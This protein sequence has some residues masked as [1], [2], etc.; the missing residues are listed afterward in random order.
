MDSYFPQGNE[1]TNISKYK[2]KYKILVTQ[3]KPATS[4]NEARAVLHSLR[5]SSNGKRHMRPPHSDTL[6]RR[7][8]LILLSPVSI[9][10]RTGVADT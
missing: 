3:V 1:L 4:S 7:R 2:Y 9:V 8:E 6:A 5:K 10:L